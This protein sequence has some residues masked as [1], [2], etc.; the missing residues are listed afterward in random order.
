MNVTVSL[1]I[2]VPYTS[3]LEIT[4]PSA[5]A[6]NTAMI[7]VTDSHSSFN[8]AVDGPSECSL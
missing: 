1:A 5:A 3:A 8:L 6:L 2:Q 4:P 7:L